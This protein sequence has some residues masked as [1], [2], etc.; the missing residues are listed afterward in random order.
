MPSKL[1]QLIA[2]KAAPCLWLFTAVM[3]LVTM[4]LLVA[5][6]K[7]DQLQETV[8]GLKITSSAL[9]LSVVRFALLGGCSPCLL[10]TGLLDSS[11]CRDSADPL[12][13]LWFVAFLGVIVIEN[14]GFTLPL[15]CQGATSGVLVYE[16]IA[17]INSPTRNATLFRGEISTSSKDTLITGIVISVLATLMVVV[18]NY[19]WC[20]VPETVSYVTK[21][22]LSM[23]C[24]R[25]QF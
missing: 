14:T 17:V 10:C 21:L 3:C 25:Y 4:C 11:Y 8:A 1:E 16:T 15:L 7:I 20:R 9:G 24:P 23:R 13:L 2:N 19:L 18:L 12:V 5:C 22:I 6:Y